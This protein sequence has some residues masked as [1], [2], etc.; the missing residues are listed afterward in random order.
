MGTHKDMLTQWKVDALER[1]QQFREND[2]KESYREINRKKKEEER[3]RRF[4][5]TQFLDTLR[6]RT[7]S[8]KRQSDEQP[9]DAEEDM[10]GKEQT[11]PPG[12]F[13][14]KKE[15]ALFQKSFEQEERQ[16]RHAEREEKKRAQEAK[17]G[18]V[19]DLKGKDP[20]AA[21]ILRV[22]QWRKEDNSKKTKTE[23]ARVAKEIA[24]EQEQRN[25]QAE[26][27]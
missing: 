12:G 27:R 21:E 19:Q 22:M 20:S 7:M 18:K 14:T 9:E 2:R 11:A 1:A 4:R 26:E 15:A 8:P 3:L 25:M 5:E 13:V 17:K 10:A 23:A 24:Q 16:K 6:G